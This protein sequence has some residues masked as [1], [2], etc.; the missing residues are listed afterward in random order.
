VQMAYL[1][2]MNIL[3]VLAVGL[4]LLP[5]DKLTSA[6]SIPEVS[7]VYPMFQDTQGL[8][9]AKIGRPALKSAKNAFLMQEPAVN[10]NIEEE[11]LL[12][13][14]AGVVDAEQLMKEKQREVSMF[15]GDIDDCSESSNEEE[16]EEVQ[17]Q[18]Q[19]QP[20]KDKLGL[21]RGA[22]KSEVNQFNDLQAFDHNI[23]DADNFIAP[24]V[25]DTPDVVTSFE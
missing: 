9:E 18:Q 13:V 4:H 8:T 23:A 10:L 15:F 11:D 19:Q 16:E 25:A 20:S 5:P 21:L 3:A 6:D 22:M 14:K 17:Q 7:E 12:E 2:V 24:F 1:N